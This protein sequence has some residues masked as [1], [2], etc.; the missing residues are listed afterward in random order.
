M[1]TSATHLNK[2]YNGITQTLD[3]SQLIARLIFILILKN[4]RLSE[5]LGRKR[6]KWLSTMLKLKKA[7]YPLL[8]RARSVSTVRKFNPDAI[9][10]HEFGHV[11]VISNTTRDAQQSN[12]SAEMADCHRQDITKALI[13]MFCFLFKIFFTDIIPIIM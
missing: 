8:A 2:F 4:A 10:P 1:F 6:L 13:D 7:T 12:L 9:L 11:R 5:R 3:S